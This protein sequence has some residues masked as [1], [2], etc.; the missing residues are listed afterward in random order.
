MGS[1]PLETI[2]PRHIELSYLAGFFDVEGCVL[3]DRIQV[4]NTNPLILE[5]YYSFFNGGTIALKKPKNDK[6]RA[7]YRWTAYGEIAR[8]AL[9][10][11]MPYLIEKKEQALINLDIL[12][13]KRSSPERAELIYKLKH[14]KRVNYDGYRQP[15]G[16]R[17][18]GR[19]YQR[20]AKEA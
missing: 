19:N 1:I 7:C 4:D 18:D 5:K 14:L 20:T 9:R 12:N 3:P 6:M 2:G 16:V 17:G 10:E 13:H 15:S 11:M 8:N